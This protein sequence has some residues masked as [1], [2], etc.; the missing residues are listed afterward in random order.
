MT[1]CVTH[2]LWTNVGPPSTFSALARL[3]IFNSQHYSLF[4]ISR[5]PSHQN[6]HPSEP[7]SSKKLVLMQQRRIWM[8]YQSSCSACSIR[9]HLWTMQTLQLPHGLAVTPQRV[10]MPFWWLS[11]TSPRLLRQGMPVGKHL[12]CHYEVE[13]VD[14][15]SPA[16]TLA[17]GCS[18]RIY[19]HAFRLCWVSV[20]PVC[21]HCTHE[22]AR[23]DALV[24]GV[25]CPRT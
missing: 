22:P 20:W 11:V 14:C 25:L 24:C 4:N 18:A 12:R 2:F 8:W 1:Q 17:Y 3:W 15:T 6:P 7:L 9:A 23:D 16:T 10:L 21:F 13:H 5:Y 19:M